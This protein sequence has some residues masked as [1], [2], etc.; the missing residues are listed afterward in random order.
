[1]PVL[2]GQVVH[3][4]EDFAARFTFLLPEDFLAEETLFPMLDEL[5][6]RAGDMG[7][8][9]VLCEINENHPIYNSLRRAG[10]AAF[11]WQHIW[12]LPQEELAIPAGENPWEDCRAIDE[13]LVRSLYQSVVPPLVQSNEN[14]M[15][16]R[17]SGWLVRRGDEVIAYAEAQF[18][19]H[20]ILL[21]TI[22]HP[23]AGNNRDLILHLIACLPRLNRPVY[24]AIRLYQANIEHALGELDAEHSPMKALLVKHLTSPL[25]AE[26]LFR[27]KNAL[28]M[29]HAEPTA[30]MI[31]NARGK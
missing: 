27:Q 11:A 31:R 18:G 10:F 23:E 29:R 12:K 6:C 8:F 22:F 21:N 20:G 7:A 24:M 19:T 5:T 3:H 17:N 13:I 9:S 2:M 1:M 15:P 14:P 16:S 28:K 30:P 26:V 25:K 4:K